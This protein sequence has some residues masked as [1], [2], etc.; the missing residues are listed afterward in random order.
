MSEP[1]DRD[2][3]ERDEPARLTEDEVER[4]LG[5][6]AGI[7]IMHVRPQARVARQQVARD[8]VTILAGAVIAVLG[9]R[10]LGGGLGIPGTGSPSPTEIVTGSEGPAGSPVA[11]ATL[12][13]P[14]T[15]GPVVNPSTNLGASPTPVPVKTLGPATL[16]VVVKVSNDNGGNDVA[17][18]WT[19]SISGANPSLASFKGSAAGTTVTIQE[20]TAYTITTSPKTKGGYTESQSA[21]CS[22]SVGKGYN[23]TCTISEDDKPVSLTVTVKMAD[24]TPPG[25]AVTVRQFSKVVASFDGAT[26]PRLILL[27]ANAKWT[28]TAALAGYVASYSADCAPSSGAP[29]GASRT[30]TI[31]FTPSPTASPPPAPTPTEPAPTPTETPAP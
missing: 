6:G 13:E 25:G 2:L 9:F 12:G 3:R 15:I 28:V 31:T 11:L 14:A 21:R 23:V 4:R 18:D 5:G 17:S 7:R 30:C 24:L 16:T 10:L 20:D 1:P 8:T 19:V 26:T 22:G 27:D 29:E